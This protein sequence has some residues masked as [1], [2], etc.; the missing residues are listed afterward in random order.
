MKMTEKIE[1]FEM[2]LKY[3]CKKAK[4]ADQINSIRFN[5]KYA[6][7]NYT[8]DVECYKHRTNNVWSVVISNS[9]FYVDYEAMSNKKLD[10][11]LHFCITD[12]FNKLYPNL[13]ANP[14][15]EKTYKVSK[16]DK[17]LLNWLYDQ[18]L[19]NYQVSYLEGDDFKLVEF[20]TGLIGVLKKN[21]KLRL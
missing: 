4:I 5:T 6:F 13:K 15:I 16:T 1:I 14:A 18:A 3:I 7:E 10:E 2:N 19:P 9:E 20:V 8:F 11:F 21:E 17:E 12:V